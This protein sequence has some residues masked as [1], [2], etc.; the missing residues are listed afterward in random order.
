[1]D[2]HRDPLALSGLVVRHWEN[3]LARIAGLREVERIAGLVAVTAPY[4]EARPASTPRTQSTDCGEAALR[5]VAAR[6]SPYAS[7]VTTAASGRRD[8]SKAEKACAS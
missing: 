4:S 8:P 6:P 2:P 5:S 1:M 7:Q 3:G